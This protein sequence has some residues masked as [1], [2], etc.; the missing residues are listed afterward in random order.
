MELLRLLASPSSSRLDWRDGGDEPLEEHRVMPVG[1]AQECGE[2]D[3]SSVDHNARRFVPGLP[4]SVVP[5]ARLHRP[6]FAGT[7]AESSE[8]CYVEVLEYHPFG[9]DAPDDCGHV[10]EHPFR[11]VIHHDEEEVRFA[12]LAGRTRAEQVRGC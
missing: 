7:L 4:L 12:R 8:V 9:A 3:L 6:P 5:Q 1:A 11:H 2:G 10:L